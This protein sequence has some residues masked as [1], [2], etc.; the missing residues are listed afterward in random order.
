[1]CV[2]TIL[3][4]NIGGKNKNPKQKNNISQYE[5]IMLKMLFKS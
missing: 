4:T 1:M 5:I 2:H 3:Q